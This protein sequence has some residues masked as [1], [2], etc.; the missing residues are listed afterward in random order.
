MNNSASQA[1]L[2][3]Q[4]FANAGSGT[5]GLSVNGVSSCPGSEAVETGNTYYNGVTYTGN[6]YAAIVYDMTAST[7]SCH[8]LGIARTQ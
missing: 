7:V 2:Y 8:A 3:F 1:Q 4:Q 5:A 6:A